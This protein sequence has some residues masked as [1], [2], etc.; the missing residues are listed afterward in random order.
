[1]SNWYHEVFLH[2]PIALQWLAYVSLGLH[3]VVACWLFY[4]AQRYEGRLNPLAWA[5]GALAFAEPAL[6]LYAWRT[7]S[8][9]A[10]LAFGV[11]ALTAL[12]MIGM[13]N[14]PIEQAVDLQIGRTLQSFPV[15][16][17]S[18]GPTNS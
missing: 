8:P 15:P 4:D 12:V 7:G 3:A 16:G 17:V 9:R 11:T 5:I 18:T 1:M 10:L 13:Y 2:W 6:G 14:A